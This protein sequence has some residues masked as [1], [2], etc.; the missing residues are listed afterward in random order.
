M[1]RL[2]VPAGTDKDTAAA[3]V[4]VRGGSSALSSAL[5]VLGVSLS[6]HCNQRL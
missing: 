6:W 5:E 1:N 4:R 3:V 2:R